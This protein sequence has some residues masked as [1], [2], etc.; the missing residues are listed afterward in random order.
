MFKGQITAFFK[1]HKK[2][3]LRGTRQTPKMRA[4]AS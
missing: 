2:H 1:Q 3:T 4:V